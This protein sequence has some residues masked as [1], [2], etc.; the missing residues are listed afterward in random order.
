MLIFQ[1]YIL[2]T[3]FQK[4]MDLFSLIRSTSRG[5]PYAV[6]VRPSRIV[7]NRTNKNAVYMIRFTFK[8]S[9]VKPVLSKHCS[10]YKVT[11][12][13]TRDYYFQKLIS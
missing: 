7:K 10:T 11:F 12:Q 8:S 4:S 2:L 6:A 1:A 9:T 5:E 3:V 13:F